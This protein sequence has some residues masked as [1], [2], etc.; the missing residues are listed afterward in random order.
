MHGQRMGLVALLVGA[1]V[2]GVVGLVIW[3]LGDDDSPED[4]TQV[5]TN[6]TDGSQTSEPGNDDSPASLTGTWEGS[7]ACAQGETPLV[8]TL[9]DYGNGDLDATFELVP[10]EVD[11]EEI[12]HGFRMQG[13]VS[14]ETLTLE[15]QDWFGQPEGYEMVG[16]LAD[17]SEQSGSDQLTGTVDGEGCTEFTVERTSAEPWYVGTWDGEYECTQGLTGITLAVEDRGDFAVEASYQFYEVAQN[18][19]VPS[20]SYRLTGAF[21]DGAMS[22]QPA[23]WIDQPSGYIMVPIESSAA[24]PLPPSVMAGR[25]QD[26][27]CQ[28]FLLFKREE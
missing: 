7:Y 8:L 2:G 21:A 14:D 26:P 5:V 15:G 19:G 22:L 3:Q 11:S 4:E 10:P 6:Q 1:L 13:T 28:D 18:P 20:G 25:V 17:L 24:G 12:D 9:T 16:L 23:E 27:G